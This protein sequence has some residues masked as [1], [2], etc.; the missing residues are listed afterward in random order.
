MLRQWCWAAILAVTG[1][2]SPVTRAERALDR[3]GDGE[4][5]AWHEARYVAEA[6]VL[7]PE[8]RED[9]AAWAIRGTVYLAQLGD[10]ALAHLETD[11]VELSLR[12]FE[13][14]TDLGADGPI[15]DRMRLEVP[16]LE[17]VVQ[18]RLATDV[19]R[20]NWGNAAR[21]L[22]LAQRIHR[23]NVSIGTADA[24]REVALR[25][26]ACRVEAEA[27]DV[28]RA[29]DHYEALVAITQHHE[30]PLVL[31]VVLA[32]ADRGR[33]HRARALADAASVEFPSELDLFEVRIGLSIELG[34][35]V[36]AKAIVDDRRGWL[37]E[38]VDGAS[39]A[40]R[41][42]ARIKADGLARLMWSRVLELDPE[43]FTAH[44]AL[45]RSLAR[46]ARSMRSALGIG[47]PSDDDAL[48]RTNLEVLW[49]EA[50]AHLR[51]AHRIDP[52]R[53]GPVEGLVEL[54]TL[55]W[56]D[57]DPEL[58]SGSAR[59]AYDFDQL[60]YQAARSMLEAR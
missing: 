8:T 41:L 12:S 49:R 22:D 28:A 23:V 13:A 52:A 55:K 1:C 42:Y 34:D 32:L 9:P 58:L 2:A 14:A 18:H 47:S 11:P 27:G 35:L 40:A 20:R 54:Y 53:R 19:D 51:R 48:L 59:D 15:R 5:H 45:G 43:H 39:R 17:A 4:P 33:P 16:E 50:E 37:S 10:P 38:S 21:E 25:R 6:A 24:Q 44:H 56:M 26:L 7:D 3:F 30:M 46:H 57:V 31:D 60:R 29:A 36:T